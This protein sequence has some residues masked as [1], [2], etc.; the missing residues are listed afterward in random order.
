MKKNITYI[1]LF[2]LIILN[3]ILFIYHLFDSKGTYIILDDKNVWKVENDNYQYTSPIY[4]KR[5]NYQ[6][7]TLYSD[8]KV[9]G[10]LEIEND[11]F[12]FYTE[13]LLKMDNLYNS[14][15]VIGNLNIKNYTSL[16]T[17]KLTETDIE[18]ISKYAK[19]N[20]LD[21]DRESVIMQKASL[22]HN[23]TIYSVVTKLEDSN[24]IDSYSVIFAKINE[25][26][27][28]LY[29]NINNQNNRYSNINKLV[30]IN[31][32]GYSDL[33]F[34]SDVTNNAGNECYSLYMYN[35]SSNSFTKNIKCEGDE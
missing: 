14:I 9:S 28:V 11:K 1:V 24:L 22:P 5:L 20:A 33:I 32:D 35:Q 26:I 30:D 23:I 21:F 12:N 29:S 19:E 17:S 31:D 3:L 27:Q 10:Y 2:V 6:S 18:E 25:D 34:L 15:I 13:N 7:A 16:L 4:L 8:N